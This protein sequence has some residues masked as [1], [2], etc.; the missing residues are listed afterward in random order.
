MC[1]TIPAK[2]VQ[3]SVDLFTN[4]PSLMEVHVTNDTHFSNFMS[5][6]LMVKA[7]IHLLSYLYFSKSDSKI[8]SFFQIS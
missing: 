6:E 1:Q 8:N 5:L 4:I 7:L 2:T 3:L